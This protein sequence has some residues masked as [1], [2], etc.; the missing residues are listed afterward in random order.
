MKKIEIFNPKDEKSVKVLQNATESIKAFYEKN[1]DRLNVNE[2]NICLN[3][4]N[5][6]K[7]RLTSLLSAS[8]KAVNNIKQKG[9]YRKG[10]PY[11]HKDFGKGTIESVQKVDDGVYNIEVKFNPPYGL[12]KLRVKEKEKPGTPSSTEAPG[13]QE[14]LMYQIRQLILQCQP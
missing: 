13:L 14:N 3:R 5:L 10:R 8:D 7:I 11:V 12:K 6:I 9:D 1:N 2:R 4:L